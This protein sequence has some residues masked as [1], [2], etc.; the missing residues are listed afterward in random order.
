MCY[1][2][3]LGFDF[4]ER[5][6]FFYVYACDSDK[7]WLKCKDMTG[8][9]LVGNNSVDNKCCF[10]CLCMFMYRHTSS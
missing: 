8:L 5:L 2:E 9:I 4:E 3:I 7:E 10:S 6:Y 1:P